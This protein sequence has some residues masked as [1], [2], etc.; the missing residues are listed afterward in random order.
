MEKIDTTVVQLMFISLCFFRGLDIS[1][2]CYK[3]PLLVD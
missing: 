1:C 2:R 3:F